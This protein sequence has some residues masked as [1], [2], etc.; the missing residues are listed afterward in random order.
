[1]A[2]D[3]IDL[4][5]DKKECNLGESITFTVQIALI[6]L[7]VLNYDSE[8]VNVYEDNVL[9]DS[10]VDL[11]EDY[12]YTPSTSGTHT[13]KIEGHNYITVDITVTGTSFNFL[14][15]NN[16]EVSSITIN[17]KEVQSIKR[18]SDDAIIYE[19]QMLEPLVFTF[20]GTTLTQNSNGS[21]NGTDMRIDY[22]DGTIESTTGK[23]GHTYSENGTY[24]VKIYGVTSLGTSCFQGCTSLAS[25]TIPNSVTGL[26]R[27][28]F[29]NCTSLTSI[30]IPNSV[31]SLGS[32]CFLGCSDLTSIVIPDSVTSMSISCFYGCTNL[33]SITLNWIGADILTYNSNWITN[34]NNNLKFKIPAGTK[35]LYIDKGY[36]ADKLEEPSAMTLT[37]TGSSFSTD[38][39]TPFTYNDKVFVDWG[40]DTGLTEYNGGQLSHTFND[41]LNSHTVKVYGDL[42]SLR[43]Q[44][45]FLCAGLTA[46]NIPNGVTSLGESCFDTCEGLTSIA[47][48]DSVTSLEDFCFY[49]CTGLTSITI[50]DNVT[51]LG[52]SCFASCTSLTSITIPD[53]VTSLGL[54]CFNSC[55]SLISII[56]P[57]NVTNLGSSCFFNCAGLTSIT[58]NW[59]ETDI[60]PFNSKWITNANS[61]LK[62]KIP[63]GTT[64]LYIDKGYPE[65]KLEEV[66]T[67]SD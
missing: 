47:I 54:A 35:Q 34:A 41:G 8:G 64:Q 37:V 43:D 18:V 45:F 15:I 12:S 55:T 50:P 67:L 10:N 1:M 25:I 48:P 31:T 32:N 16:K 2:E 49:N 39:S 20:E 6:Y 24:Q 11:W 40:D 56:I 3:S 13:I 61:S 60:L 51:N 9:I 14:S 23:F 46:I 21:F 62:F 38:S 17:S 53:S 4:Y 33:T 7:G 57:N 63:A 66:I 30:T 36:P 44:C 19:K 65:D 22:G 28:C 59:T 58:L 26:G 5:C 52:R 42:T 29:W 27:Y